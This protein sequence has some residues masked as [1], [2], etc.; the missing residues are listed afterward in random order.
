MR[1]KAVL[2][3]DLA[4]SMSL[5]ALARE[6]GT[7]PYHLCRVFRQR[8]GTT[9]HSYRLD[10][11]VRTAL[12]R[13]ARPGADLSQLALELGFSSHSHF[14]AVL[15]QRLGVPPSAARRWLR[16]AGAPVRRPRRDRV[17]RP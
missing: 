3:R 7:S 6:L 4:C 13:L 15:R 14:T 8:A 16:A 2:A 12:E 9:L 11:R 1:A 5:A 17:D 10:L